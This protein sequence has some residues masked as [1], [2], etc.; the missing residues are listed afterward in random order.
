MN[1]RNVNPQF[2]IW[3]DFDEQAWVKAF[4]YVDGTRK[5]E[6]VTTESIRANLLR[7]DADRLAAALDEVA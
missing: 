4:R 3:Y 5:G 7:A 2:D 1:P 6:Y